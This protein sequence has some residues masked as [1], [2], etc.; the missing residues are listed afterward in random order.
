MSGFDLDFSDVRLSI[1][2]KSLGYEQ[3]IHIRRTIILSGLQMKAKGIGHVNWDKI[4]LEN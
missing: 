3:Y 4:L 1:S 2:P